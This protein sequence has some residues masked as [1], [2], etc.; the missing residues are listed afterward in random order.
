MT[1]NVTKKLTNVTTKINNTRL[2]EIVYWLL[3]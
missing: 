2:N 1:Y 3:L